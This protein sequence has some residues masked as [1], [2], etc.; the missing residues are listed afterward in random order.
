MT[1]FSSDLSYCKFRNLLGGCK[2]KINN[3]T[4]LLIIKYI[5]DNCSYGL[6]LIAIYN[7]S[8]D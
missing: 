5:V 3:M 4:D 6:V 2:F 1:T 8:I 7:N